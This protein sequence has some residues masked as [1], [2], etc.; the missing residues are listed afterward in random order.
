M[1]ETPPKPIDVPECIALR[2]KEWNKWFT[3]HNRC[4]YTLGILGVLSSSIAALT[5]QYLSPFCAVISTVAFGVLG[6]VQPSKQYVRYVAAWRI[7]DAA[8]SKYRFGFISLAEL[9]QAQERGEEIIAG[10]ESNDS[11]P[12]PK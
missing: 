6:F 7:L 2:L 4:Y 11:K 9:I 12:S 5:I 1:N 3:I 10:Y 8:V